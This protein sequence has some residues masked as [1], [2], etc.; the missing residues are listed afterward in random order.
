MGSY[1]AVCI[2]GG[3]VGGYF[4]DEALHTG[5]ILTLSGLALGLAAAFYGGY[6]MLMDTIA[7]IQRWDAATAQAKRKKQGP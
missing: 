4:L 5:K 2:A 6:R 1:V 7:E 3:T